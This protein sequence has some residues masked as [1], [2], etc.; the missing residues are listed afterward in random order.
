MQRLMKNK[1][2]FSDLQL[3]RARRTFVIN[4]QFC[5]SSDMSIHCI[6]KYFFFTD[7]INTH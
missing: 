2:E 4:T 3:N 5:V 1:R 6:Y 7:I